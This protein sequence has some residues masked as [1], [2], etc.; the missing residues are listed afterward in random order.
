MCYP[1]TVEVKELNTDAELLTAE[2]PLKC[3][4]GACKCCCYQEILVTSD[5]EELGKA[6]ET[7]YYCVPQY[8][9]A[10]HT[11]KDVYK[12]HPP[13]CCG[14]MCMNC[15]TE[16]N[17]CCGKGC[18]K[19][20]FWIFP[21]DGGSDE[22]DKI[23]KILKKPKSLMTE[24]FTDAVALDIDFPSDS[25]PALKGLLTASALLLNSNYF[26]KQDDNN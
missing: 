13:L 6:Y 4:G 20:P 10:D 7:C 22:E 19:V 1:Y 15:C 9:V 23:G 11:G 16:G 17:P 2:R 18:C 14:G 8:N 24:I 3:A 21:I 12:I 5:G 26:E 25:T